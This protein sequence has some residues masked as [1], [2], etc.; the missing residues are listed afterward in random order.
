MAEHPDWVGVRE[1]VISKL[2]KELPNDLSY[3]GVQH[4]RDDVLPAA[5]HLAELAKLPPADRLLLRTAA[6][7]HD[8]G[9]IEQYRQNEIIAV[10]IAWETLPEFGYRNE[11]IDRIERI[12]LATEMPQKPRDYL[13]QIMCDADLDSLGRKDFFLTSYQLLQERRNYGENISFNEW[14]HIQIDFL[15]SHEY[16]TDVARNLRGDSKAKNLHYLK[17]LVER[18]DRS[19]Q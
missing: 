17:K 3:H 11:Q 14:R 19:D 12:I 18:L 2:A 5:E 6:L 4:T 16:F 10:R 7:L 8:T 13:E 15:L 9:Y 1:Y